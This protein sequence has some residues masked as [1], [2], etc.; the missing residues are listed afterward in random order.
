MEGMTRIIPI[1]I[2]VFAL[3]LAGCGEKSK[4][5]PIRGEVKALDAGVKTATIAHGPIGDW[6]GAMTM[7]F[8]VKP[9]SDFLKLHVGDRIVG[10]VVVNDLSYYVT[11]VKVVRAPGS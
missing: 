2:A 8:P 5:Y 7:E 3:A 1:L 4:R 9:D 10:T 6:M 11:D